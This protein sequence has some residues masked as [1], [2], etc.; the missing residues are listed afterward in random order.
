MAQEVRIAGATY[1]NVPS[2]SVPDSNNTYHSF[3]DVSDTTAAASDVASG[4]YFYL[5][6]GTKTTG[7]GSGGTPSVT[8]DANGYI[9]LDDEAGTTIQ[10][11]SLSVTTNGTYTAATGH[12]YS[13]VTVSVSGG[14]GQYAWLGNG[15]EKVG[16]VFS[17]TINLKDDTGYD[18]WIAS[19]TATTLVEASTADDYTLSADVATYDYCLVTKGFIEP[20]YLSGTQMTYTTKRVCQ[21]YVHYYFGCPNTS[22][23][24]DVQTDTAGQ[25]G[26]ASTTSYLFV[27]Y[28]YNNVGTIVSRSATQCGALY[29][30]TYPS[31]SAGVVSDGVTSVTY[32]LPAFKAKCDSSRFTTTRK[33]QVDSANTNYIVT[34]DLY[35][36]P[37]G[38]GIFSHFV[39]EMCADM[40]A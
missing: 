9:V 15:A 28:Y 16:T 25:L 33:T 7:T 23:T 2:I 3:T 29:M 27:Q 38:N 8:Q 17:K 19:T 21:Y 1:Q 13:P 4:K 31:I 10:V 5:A 34:L 40:N 11:E 18:D 6:N 14:G 36:V 39:S 20:V 35:R 24:S 12:A 37:H 26:Y 22:T 30:S 32:R